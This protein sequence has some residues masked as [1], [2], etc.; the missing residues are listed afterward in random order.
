MSITIGQSDEISAPNATSLSSS[1][2]WPPWADRNSTPS[3][4]HV[5]SVHSHWTR[6]CIRKQ[7][8]A[9]IVRNATWKPLCVT[10]ISTQHLSTIFKK[11]VWHLFYPWQNPVRQKNLI[12]IER[13]DWLLKKIEFSISWNGQN[14]GL[15]YCIVRWN[16]HRFAF[17]V[18]SWTMICTDT[19]LCN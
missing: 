6:A 19:S 12:W 5:L 17:F 2:L 18:K 11:R 13:S 9:L 4:S 10:S 15:V 8:D 7:E 1:N 14:L 3:I 16:W